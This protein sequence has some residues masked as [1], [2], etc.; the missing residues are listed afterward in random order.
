MI[1]ET[2][3][4]IVAASWTITALVAEV[5]SKRLGPLQVNVIR[6]V[7]SLILLST[8]LWVATGFPYPIHTDAK[9]W[10]WLSASGFVG[11][12]LGDYCLF[13]S[14]ILIGSRFGQLFMTLAAPFAAIAAWVL[15]GE[16]MTWMGLLGMVLTLT[17]IGMS[18]LGRSSAEG[19]HAHRVSVGLPL[20]GILLGIGAGA[21]QG[22]GLV[23][24]KVGL[25]QY[26]TLVPEGD[27]VMLFMVP[28]AGTMIRAITG[29]VCFAGVMA[30]NHRFE[31]L[32]AALGDFKGMH[33][34]FWASVTGPF[35]G[36]SLSLMAV[37]YANAGIAQCLMS[38]TPILILWPSHVFFGT[39]VTLKE[40]A[41]ACIAVGGATLFFI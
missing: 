14:Y 29:L 7:L 2:I 20:K 18:I 12:V 3:S 4:L 35:V 30:Y 17:G 26:T 40:I 36:V 24:S 33:A 41:G 22:V 23:L 39:K 25:E 6:M 5:A 31:A 9:V 32:K 19:Q 38:L 34:V 15:L 37:Q 28:F 11:Y 21:G 1:G 27:K 16:T 8:T 10:A 13:N